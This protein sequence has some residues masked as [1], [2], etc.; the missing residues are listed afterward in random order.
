MRPPSHP[1]DRQAQGRSPRLPCDHDPLQPE[2][3]A[4]GSGPGHATRNA[5]AL[6][7]EE[8][9]NQFSSASSELQQ[10]HPNQNIHYSHFFR[11]QHLSNVDISPSFNDI[12]ARLSRENEIV[13]LFKQKLLFSLQNQNNNNNNSS[14]ALHPSFPHLFSND[15]QQ[16]RKLQG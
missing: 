12:L 10:H 8:V 7:D 16:I 6:V 11:N 3:R 14:A 13:P 1:A 15:D 9:F 5:P 2:R 4:N